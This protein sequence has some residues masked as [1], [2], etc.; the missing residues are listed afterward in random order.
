MNTRDPGRKFSGFFYQGAATDT[1]LRLDSAV[2]HAHVKIK[3]EGLC[4]KEREKEKAVHWNFDKVGFG[5]ESLESLFSTVNPK[6]H[7][8]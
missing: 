4:R 3:E 8:H 2:I 7:K 6:P 1:K 5:K